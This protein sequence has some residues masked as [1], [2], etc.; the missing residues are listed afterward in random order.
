MTTIL[1]IRDLARNIDKLQMY[2]FVD[3]ED[4][5]THEYKGLF[6]SPSY[7]KEFKEYLEKK[8]Q[9]EKKEK[10]LRLKK[11]AGSGTIDDKYAKLSSREIKEAVALEKTHE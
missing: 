7:A 6:L 5:K 11:Y 9:K 1:G 8:S 2:D 4:K 3:I 10:L